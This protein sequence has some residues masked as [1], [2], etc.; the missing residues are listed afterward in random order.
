MSPYLD[1]SRLGLVGP[2]HEFAVRLIEHHSDVEFTAGRRSKEEQA[3][4]MATNIVV[5]KNRNWISDTYRPTS[6]S[7][8]LQWWLTQ[9][10]AAKS[11]DE[12]AAGL[13]SI[14]DNL[15]PQSLE[16]LSKHFTGKAVDVRPVAEL[17]GAIIL[18]TI[19]SLCDEMKL[20]LIEREGGL[21]RW[22][23][24]EK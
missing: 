1:I 24:Q 11:R 12:I 15:V 19:K 10:P 9:H 3:A 14:M 23:I 6:A 18:Q 2:V 20:K 16:K 22:H 7:K 17:H 4:A 8:K 21:V 13:L 5:S